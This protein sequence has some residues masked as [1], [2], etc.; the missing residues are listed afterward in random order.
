MTPEAVD[1]LTNSQRP[2]KASIE[3]PVQLSGHQPHVTYP[4]STKKETHQE[5]SKAIA[6]PTTPKSK[7]YTKSQLIKA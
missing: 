1:S 4:S 6:A 7:T 3:K 5:I 2:E